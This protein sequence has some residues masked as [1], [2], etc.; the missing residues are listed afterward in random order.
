LVG[1]DQAAQR[2][3][4]HFISPEVRDVT[5]PWRIQLGARYVF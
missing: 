1:Y 4:Y 5:E 2:G 3:I